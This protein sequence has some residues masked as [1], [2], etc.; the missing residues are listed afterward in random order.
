L[1]RPST[2]PAQ[3]ALF[4]TEVEA[5]HRLPYEHVVLVRRPVNAGD[6]PCQSGHFHGASTGR[7]R[8]G[9][10]YALVADPTPKA[11]T[12]QHPGRATRI[13][14]QP[15]PLCGGSGFRQTAAATQYLRTRVSAVRRVLPRAGDRSAPQG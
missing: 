3:K 13:T 11:L 4:P 10:S 14:P 7:Y 15:R 12:S 8:C 5:S 6:T 9:T 1:W 2:G